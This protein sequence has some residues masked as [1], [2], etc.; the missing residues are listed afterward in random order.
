MWLWTLQVFQG[1][2]FLKWIT[3]LKCQF[4]TS[5]VICHLPSVF[6]L[7]IRYKFILFKLYAEEIFIFSWTTIYFSFWDCAYLF[8][9]S[10]ELIR[11][12]CSL[13]RWGAGSSWA[14]RGGNSTRLVASLAPTFFYH[15]PPFLRVKNIINFQFHSKIFYY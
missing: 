4:S 10:D 7:S 14:T 12:P 11:F 15:G 8:T 6:G 1:T 13:E 3:F 2:H 5:Y 9:L